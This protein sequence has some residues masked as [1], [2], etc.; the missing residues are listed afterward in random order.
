M[1]LT[2]N[3]LGVRGGRE[4]NEGS[5]GIGSSGD[6]EVKDLRGS[7]RMIE[8]KLEVIRYPE[9]STQSKGTGKCGG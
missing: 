7:G 9:Q 2:F 8:G 1:I 6:G 3:I 5:T 4:T